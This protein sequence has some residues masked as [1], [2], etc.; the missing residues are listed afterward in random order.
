M[1]VNRGKVVK[2]LFGSVVAV[3]VLGGLWL[4]FRD[5]GFVAVHKATVIGVGGARSDR[6]RAA[7]LSQTTLNVDEQA[8]KDAGAGQPPISAIEV[9]TSFPDAMTIRVQLY[10][11]VAAVSNGGA[12]AVAVSADGTILRGVST[13]GLPTVDGIAGAGSVR[14]AGASEAIQ[15]LAPAPQALLPRIAKA[16]VDSKRGV[17]VVM[18]S[19]PKIYFGAPSDAAA[20]WAAAARVLADSATAGASY[21]DVTVPRR[22]AVGG[23]QGGVQGGV[24][25]ADPNQPIG[26]GSDPNTTDQ[27][28]G[29][30]TGST[31][32]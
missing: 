22:P 3:V 10:K 6:I 2:Y 5:S 9:S 11:P 30:Q 25:P 26:Q 7:A 31:G 20:K 16:Y 17:V 15:V 19:G 12:R 32:Q 28:Q 13:S 1:D 4:V 27:T 18:R 23:V 8:L 14:T 24:D 29:S 21:I